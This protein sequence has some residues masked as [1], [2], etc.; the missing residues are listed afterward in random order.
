[1]RCDLVFN[2]LWFCSCVGSSQNIVSTRNKA[3]GTM[4]FCGPVSEPV[5]AGCSP[6]M[7][8]LRFVFLNVLRN[9]ALQR[10]E[11]DMLITSSKGAGSQQMSKNCIQLTYQYVSHDNHFSYVC[12][13]SPHLTVICRRK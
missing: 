8:T 11:F 13:F 6:I 3:G 9:A 4:G 1:M 12:T 7:L 2:R 10:Q 5:T